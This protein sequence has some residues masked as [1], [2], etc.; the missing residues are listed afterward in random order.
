MYKNILHCSLHK[1]RPINEVKECSICAALDDSTA[2][3]TFKLHKQLVLIEETISQFHNN[4]Y[5]PAIMKL[6]FHLPHVKLL[7]KHHCAAQRKAAFVQR[8]ANMDITLRRDY[9]ERCVERHAIELQ[10]QH[11]GGNRSLS[12]EGMAVQHFDNDD[13]DAQ[14]IVCSYYSHLSDDSKQNAATT[15]AHTSRLYQ[16][17]KDISVLH[18]DKSTIWEVTDGCAKQYRCATAIYLMSTVSQQFD[19][20]ID[21]SIEAPGHGKG[22][23][24]G[25]GAVDKQFLYKSMLRRTA[26]KTN[27][28]AIYNAHAAT[29]K[30]VCSFVE[31]CHRLLSQEARRQRSI[32]FKNKK[33]TEREGK[34]QRAKYFIQKEEDVKF[35]HINV[36]WDNTV[37]SKL[38]FVDASAVIRGRQGIMTHYNYRVDPKLGF[39]KCAVRRIPCMCS[40]CIAQLDL[41]WDPTLPAEEQPRFAQVQTC[42]YWKI[43]EGMN[44]WIIMTLQDKGTRDTEI[45]EMHQVMLDG[46]AMNLAGFIKPNTYGA[47]AT[48]DTSSHGYYIVFFLSSPYTLQED[49]KCGDYCIDNG[50]LVCE[51][52][53]VYAIQ[54]DSHWYMFKKNDTSKILVE[55][56]TVVAHSLDVSIIVEKRLLPDKLKK[57][58]P[59][60]LQAQKPFELSLHQHDTI[61]DEIERRDR[62]EFDREYEEDE[63]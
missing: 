42:K 8:G 34:Y 30:G 23:V 18:P 51:V 45:E 12:M 36:A 54:K 50:E 43:F 31:E 55:V 61:I 37:F 59:E 21:R 46:I 52:R 41:P 49:T 57:M 11:F 7:G 40:A 28:A 62:M 33:L 38:P 48:D 2:K 19:V 24:D 60:A 27:D 63:Y 47:V 44:D 35:N 58:T 25:F 9:A 20:V 3:G 56:T 1:Q 22:E 13:T 15:T 5:K 29:K 26:T 14:S 39:G 4:Y 10:C 17:L 16:H 32:S 6:A 53:Y